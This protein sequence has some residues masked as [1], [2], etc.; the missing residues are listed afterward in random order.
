MVDGK[1][2]ESERNDYHLACILNR[3]QTNLKWQFYFLKKP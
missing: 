3:K 1:G 2:E